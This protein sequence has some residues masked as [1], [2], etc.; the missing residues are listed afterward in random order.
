MDLQTKLNRIENK[1]DII[2]NAILSLEEELDVDTMRDN[3]NLTEDAIEALEEIDSELVD[4][5]IGF[6]RFWNDWTQV[7]DDERIYEYSDDEEA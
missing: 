3:F 2:Y 5:S 4:V 7:N 1:F 6:Q